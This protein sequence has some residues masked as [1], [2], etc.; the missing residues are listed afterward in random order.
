VFVI[1]SFDLDGENHM[2][3]V[4]SGDKT[5][6]ASSLAFIDGGLSDLDTLI[7]GLPAGSHYVVLD[8]NRDGVEQMAEALAGYHDL[9]AIH[10][11]SH[12]APGS[13]K[14]GT[15]SLNEASLS[16]YAG[17]WSRIG[18]ALADTGDLLLYGCDV[19]AGATGRRFIAALANLTGA[20]VA[21]STDPTGAAGLGGDWN[22]E[23]ATGTLDS[24]AL[25]LPY[26]G[27]LGL[28]VTPNTPSYPGH[29]LGEFRN[30]G[31][32]A[33][34]KV[35]GS[36]VT[37]GSNSSG[38]DSSAVATQLDGTTPVTQI[39]STASAFAALRADGSV[40]TWGSGYRGGDSS[41]V[42][43]QLD[44]T[45]AVTQIFS[46][47]GAFAALRADGSVV[48][49]GAYGGN[50]TAVA[51]QLNG[52][53]DVTQIFSTLNAFA[54]LRA[55]GSL[56]TWGGYNYDGSSRDSVAAPLDGTIDITQIF[57][58]DSAFA[59]LRADGSVVTWGYY[60]SGGSSYSVAAPLDGT[61]DVTQIFSTA[62][63]F[64]ALRAD[65][66]VVTWGWF[67]S[68][69]DSSAVARQINGTIDVTRIFSTGNAFAAL[70]ADGSVVT[71]GASDSGGDSSKVAAQLDGTI[72][73]TQIFSTA[74]AFAAL[75]SDGSVVTWG[76]SGGDSSAVAAQLDGT[77]D[78]TQIF[79]VGLAFAALR[80]DGSVVT[81]GDS[82]YGGD[83]S[84]VAAQLDGTIDVTQIFSTDSAFAALRADGSVVTWGDSGYGGDSSAVAAKLQS[85]VVSFANIYTN[86]TYSTEGSTN[87]APAIV[88]AIP[89]QSATEY[90][91]FTYTLPSD[92]F[93][94]ADGDA[95]SY[96]ASAAGGAPLPDWLS[97]DAGMRRF[98][99]TPGDADIGPL[100]IAVTATDGW[101]GSVS[102][103][104][105]LNV[106][107]NHTPTVIHA[108][109]PQSATEYVLFTY[110][111]PSDTFD[112]ADGDALSYT[113]N[114]TDG[115]PL[116]AWL[117]FDAGTRRFSGTPGNADIGPLDLAVTASDR[118]GGSVSDTLRLNVIPNHAPTIIHA[119]P[120]QSTAKGTLFTYTLP[121]D[122]FGDA[123]GDALSYAA[124]TADG[125]AL[126][127]W[128]S[129]DAATRTFSGTPED[130]DV[131]TLAIAVTATDAWGGSVADT[132]RLN[133][134]INHAPTVVHSIPPQSASEDASFTYTLPSDTFG[135][136]DGDALSYAARA[137]DGASL[138]AWLRF[139]AGTRTFSGTPENADVGSLAI[140]VTATDRWGAS[141]T[142]TLRLEVINTNDAPVLE[143][144]IADFTVMAG[145]PLGLALAQSTF[146]DPDRGDRLSYSATLADGSPLPAWLQFDAATGT[147]RG[148][149]GKSDA[150][151]LDIQIT[152]KDGLGL[153][154]SDSFQLTV[155]APSRTLIVT[156]LADSG[157]GS[158]RDALAQAHGGDTITFAAALSGGDIPLSSTLLIGEDITLDGDLNDDHVPDISLDG[159]GAVRVMQIAGGTEVN[160]IGLRI[161]QGTV[162]GS[163][164]RDGVR[165]ADGTSDAH[166][167]G[168]SGST[169]TNGGSG[170]G[171][172]G[173]GLY[174][175]GNVMLA[176]SVFSHNTARGGNGGNG[177]AGGDGG[178]GGGTISSSSSWY[179]FGHGGGG[180]GGGG[181]GGNAIGAGIYNQGNLVLQNVVFEDN[182]AIAGAGGSGGEGGN[183]G[184]YGGGSG[185]PGKDGSPRFGSGALG[186]HGGSV[187][188]AG[189]HGDDGDPSYGGIGWSTYGE[190]PSGGGGGGG[191]GGA[192]G[193]AGAN[194][195]GGASWS[196]GIP[197][198]FSDQVIIP[199]KGTIGNSLNLDFGPLTGVD[200]GERLIWSAANLPRGIDL[201]PHAHQLIGSPT[202]SGHGTLT[203]HVEDGRGGYDD[204][205]LPWRITK[206]DLSDQTTLEAKPFRYVVP[207]DAF[208][209]MGGTLSY[210]AKLS[211]GGALPA[212]LS[213]NKGV[214]SGVP[215]DA[216]VG[217]YAL[218]V[219]ATGADGAT[220]TDTF[221]L[222]VSNINQAPSVAHPLSDPSATQDAAFSFTVPADTFVDPD[223]GD[224]LSYGAT[225]ANG[226]ALPAWLSFDA[227]TLTFSGT[228][229]NGDVGKLKIALTATDGGGAK[230]IDNFVLTVANVNDP[231]SVAHP[232]A[233]QAVTAYQAFS[234]KLPADT[235]ADPDA[236]DRLQY[237]A[238]LV[239]GGKLPA[240]LHFNAAFRAF[241]GTPSNLDLASLDIRVT[242]QDRQ[243]AAV[244][245]DFTLAVAANHHPVGNAGPNRL[246]GTPAADTLEG[247]RGNDTL[248]GGDGNDV[249]I[250]GK[251]RDFFDFTTPP[252]ARG[253]LDSLPDFLPKD[254][255]LRLAH[256]V[257]AALPT[258]PLAATAFQAGDHLKTAQDADDRIVYDT[259]SGKLY[260][261]ADG[262]GGVAA[263]P[264]AVVGITSHPK[265][266][267]QDFF[268]LG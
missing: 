114:T 264:F 258:G 134:F 261:D 23:A 112:D 103:T 250:G 172:A 59:A 110:T 182:S 139:D 97:F 241:S 124:R 113:A 251:G 96:T 74:R 100:A 234:F 49:W 22:L 80:A 54:A 129:F 176:D 128:L 7:A 168:R 175:Y 107:P 72:D 108:I 42:A 58:T 29:T 126:P 98:S 131:G 24:D 265:L 12:G 235:F 61:I 57:S 125:A 116:P 174:N 55:D 249:L 137:A 194:N 31:A 256:G 217:V 46:D 167:P 187:G 215:Q 211:D 35:H 106:I 85:G 145:T 81:W 56:V 50:S 84:A 181:A 121:S 255:T 10:V 130:A 127:A 140:A 2:S 190:N 64:A 147:I 75:R 188:E 177:G 33:V 37:W 153:T 203:L 117:S 237:A 92:T 198:A 15:A 245:D 178:S 111:L 67:Y 77:T 142:D 78:V 148:T 268:V 154:A 73:V 17:L 48:T 79:S 223:A 99:G 185:K 53:I 149:P 118:W 89:P 91:L 51:S 44:G 197:V 225:L 138:P 83:S 136:G 207:R 242:A 195:V 104:L 159:R 18:L 133:I 173:A 120:P 158:L 94:D 6:G 8:P 224:S 230:A 45:T 16:Q 263:I 186:G 9:Q 13:L 30:S 248:A 60:A 39:F 179:K 36:V 259:T 213:F 20:D 101:G 253:N 163:R 191:G 26:D 122:T 95:L 123:E 201:D 150:G 266:T 14:L 38:G 4:I 52:D 65:G 206:A 62:S 238:S 180:G 43:A 41:A 34:I 252:K 90:V 105:R 260:Y 231:P 219:T 143:N 246:D 192:P 76:G 87:H 88:H 240:W 68:G 233:D 208:S 226:A 27:V 214:F 257:Y 222:T 109:P 19:A 262:L 228:P 254:D 82:D 66:S 200:S 86:D 232:L 210:G 243:G 229:G 202:A 132:L 160:L 220:N 212:W 119:I 63:A 165:G 21:A 25:A 164:G 193:T 161:T 28:T 227:A 102:D 3:K 146:I 218:T 205:S 170:E 184:G 189:T 162:Q 135:D 236:G 183:D 152:A 157:A 196:E 5:H 155:V 71:W 244:S 69:G 141:V 267:V 144:P 32:F 239:D 40:V 221:T 247:G 199:L 11:V 209:D 93:D 166:G 204:L 156:T 216:D 171:V 70:R 47:A 1:D 151:S 115:A 169:G